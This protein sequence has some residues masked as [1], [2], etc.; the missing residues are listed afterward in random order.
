MALK[1]M[2]SHGRAPHSFLWLWL[3][4]QPPD[5]SLTSHLYFAFCDEP[6]RLCSRSWMC[7]HHKLCSCHKP[8][9]A[10]PPKHVLAHNQHHVCPSSTWGTHSHSSDLSWSYTCSVPQL[11]QG[12]C[13][14]GHLPQFGIIY[15]F[16]F[17]SL[18]W[19]TCISPSWLPLGRPGQFF[20]PLCPALSRRRAQDQ[21]VQNSHLL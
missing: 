1:D 13:L 9:A 2:A 12:S 18:L 8:E 11:R 17:I 10:P 6:M 5:F 20:S 14:P 4:H 3:F 19:P 21:W 7:S 15:L 16:I